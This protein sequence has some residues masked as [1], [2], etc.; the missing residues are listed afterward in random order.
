MRFLLLF[1]LLVPPQ[2]PSPTPGPAAAAT[3]LA[4]EWVPDVGELRVDALGPLQLRV[5]VLGERPRTLDIDLEGFAPD[6]R[7]LAARA[8]S[9]METEV[10]LALAVGSS[11]TTSYHYLL[12][13]PAE[14]EQEVARV[15]LAPGASQHAWGLSPALFESEGEP[16]RL[17]DLHNVG[18]D[19]IEIT[20]RRGFPQAV[21]FGGGPDA[22]D[23]D[24][25]LYYDV[26][27]SPLKVFGRLYEVTSATARPR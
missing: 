20:F 2:A 17:V 21:R 19:T 13:R 22:I 16:Y 25:K 14:G 6:A 1:A 10:V 27:P 23:V 24:E 8:T 3:P 7:V 18:G 15:R 11:R 12:R 9:F 5:A 26:C 4:R